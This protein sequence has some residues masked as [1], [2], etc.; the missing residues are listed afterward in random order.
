L[1]SGLD[2]TVIRGL[3]YPSMS[4]ITN[5]SEFNAGPT[6]MESRGPLRLMC[7]LNDLFTQRFP[8]TSED[9]LA[10]HLHVIGFCLGK[11]ELLLE[12]IDLDKMEWM[13]VLDFCNQVALSVPQSSSL[14]EAQARI[15]P[16]SPRSNPFSGKSGNSLLYFMLTELQ[17]PRPVELLHGRVEPSLY[18]TEIFDPKNELHLL[19]REHVKSIMNGRRFFATKDGFVGFAP[20]EA[21]IGDIVYILASGPVPYIVREAHC[22]HVEPIPATAQ[23]VSTYAFVGESY[24]AGVMDANK[25]MHFVGREDSFDELILC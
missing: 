17:H 21:E 19:W 6:W 2:G 14:Q 23:R 24:V 25:F 13:Y 18:D 11:I 5:F 10:Q 3:L 20:A 12:T 4:K 15:A 22:H 7:N 16:F 1:G 8:R 9:S